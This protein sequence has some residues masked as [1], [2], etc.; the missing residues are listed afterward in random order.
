MQNKSDSEW[1]ARHLRAALNSLYDPSVLRNSPLAELFEVN[2]QRSTV[3]ELQRIL[4]DAIESLK[5]NES[6]PS[7]SRT[8]RAYQVLRRRYT[9]QLPQSK[10]A[11]DLGLSVRQL[12]REEKRARKVLADQLWALH[13]L[14]TRVRDLVSKSSRGS[15]Q[16]IPRDARVPTRLQELEY[17]RNSVPAR[18]VQVKEVIEEVLETITPLL[19]SSQVTVEYTPQEDVPSIFLQVPMLRQALLNVIGVAIHYVAG[20]RVCLQTQVLPQQ[21]CI[22]IRAFASHDV[23]PPEEQEKVESLEMAQQLI[24]LCR[25]SL[26]T[27]RT[28]GGKEAFT[29]K[30]GVPTV[31]QVTVLVID[32]NADTLQLIQRYLSGSRYHFVGARD[33][34]RGLA[35]AEQ[36]APQIVVLDVMM[37]EQDGWTLLGQLREHPKTHTIPVI[38]CTIL[39]HEELALALGAAEFIRKPVSRPQL[40]SA[41]ERQLDRPQKEPC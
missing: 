37:P 31:E 32:D 18:M 9:E 23:S 16:E 20:G 12:Q 5:P 34:Q 15:T 3:S 17:L 38:V 19:E 7:G 14:E 40:L 29:A 10:V 35:L 36:L 33:G 26:E 11:S 25:G 21:I 39:P 24:Q 4:I 22:C 41:L 30:I 13:N 27:T 1:F 28:K 8:W 2:Q 6:A